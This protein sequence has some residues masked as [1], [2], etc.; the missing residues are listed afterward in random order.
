M[1]TPKFKCE[2]SNMAADA[3]SYF[4]DHPEAVLKET[5]YMGPYAGVD[6]NSPYLIITP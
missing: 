1:T 3:W 5:W 4:I 2:I 6:Y